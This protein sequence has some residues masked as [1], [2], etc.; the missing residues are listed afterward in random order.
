[1]WEYSVRVTHTQYALEAISQLYRD[2]ADCENG[3]AG[4]CRLLITLI[5]AASDRIK[6]MISNVRKGLRFVLTTTPPLPKENAGWPSYA[7]S[8][9]NSS[10][11]NPE[12]PFSSPSPLN[13]S[14][15][16]AGH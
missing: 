8:S 6:T 13:Q 12:T 10:P 9:R 15:Q 4:Q 14:P 1:V 11:A 2:R 3:H 5:H 16:I 7:T